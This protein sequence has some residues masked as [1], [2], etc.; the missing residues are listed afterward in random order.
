MIQELKS[1]RLNETYYRIDHPSG[2]TVLLYPMAGFS[3]AYA[4]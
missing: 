1:E 2:L 4:L 3:T